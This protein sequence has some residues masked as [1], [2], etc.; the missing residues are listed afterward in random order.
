MYYF[1]VLSPFCW[2]G[3]KTVA[4]GA[5]HAMDVSYVFNMPI[6]GD[7]VNDNRPAAEKAISAKMIKYWTNFVKYGN[8]NGDGL[9]EWPEYEPNK[10]SVMYFNDEFK[11][12]KVPNRDKLDLMEN[13]YKWKRSTWKYRN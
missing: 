5:G 9:L 11:I 4:R 1:D 7:P 13:F 12:V 8:P 3:P 6:M 2:G 10:A